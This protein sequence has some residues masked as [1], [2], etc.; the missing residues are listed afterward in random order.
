MKAGEFIKLGQ[1]SGLIVNK[2]WKK[3]SDDAL[4]SCL[5]T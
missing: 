4:P 2:I 1:E 3:K 5:A